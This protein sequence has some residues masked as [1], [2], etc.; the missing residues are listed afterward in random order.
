MSKMSLKRVNKEL[1]Y[2]FNRKYLSDNLL[3]M[4]IIFTII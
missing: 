4:N 1:E 3:K 2:F